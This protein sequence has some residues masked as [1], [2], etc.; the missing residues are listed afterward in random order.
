MKKNTEGD[1]GEGSTESEKGATTKRELQNEGLLA[2]TQQLGKT[3][4]LPFKSILVW[5]KELLA[6][7]MQQVMANEKQLLQ[8]NR[9]KGELLPLNKKNYKLCSKVSDASVL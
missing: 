1:Q 9:S 5:D 4:E 8:T 6:E 7:T 3:Y 2:I